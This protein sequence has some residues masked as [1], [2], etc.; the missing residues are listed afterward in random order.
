M[1]F[2]KASLAL[3]LAVAGFSAAAQTLYPSNP[4]KL[5]V[6]LTA[7]SGADTAGRILSQSLGKAWKQPVLIENRPGAGGLIGTSAVVNAEPNGYTLL[8][9]SAGYASNTAI[10]SK[11]PYDP[12]KS[13]VE[14]AMIGV[15]PYVMVTAS[16]S[17]YKSVQDIVSAARARPGEL[18]F[19]SVGVGSSTHFAAEHF[20]QAAG[21]KMLHVPY[22][23]G[24]EAIQDVMAGRAA[25]TMASLSTAL[26]QIRGGKLRALG[27]ASKARSDA[28]TD[29]ATIAEQGFRDFDI[30]LWFGL[31]APAGTSPAVVQK[32]S[33]D[34]AR[35]MQDPELMAAYAKIGIEPRAMNAETFA[36]YV[37]EEMKKYQFI[38]RQAR[39]EAQ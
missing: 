12:L 18:T 8:L 22:K 3:V 26:G 13:L 36:A 31:W 37:R 9:Q 21:V 35:A 39:I 28:A 4:V 11:L 34:V 2:F 24:P 1:H 25:F 30:S 29:I 38:A 27:L 7:G 17:P 20:A 16:D 32:I 10:Y 23:G 5:V 15:A 19:A 14:V 33:A 6:P